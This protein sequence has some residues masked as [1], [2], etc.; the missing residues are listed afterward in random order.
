MRRLYGLL[1][2]A[3]W[4][5]RAGV[6]FCLGV[7]AVGAM[8]PFYMVFLLIPAF[9]GLN[10]LIVSAPGGRAAAAVGWWFGLG[11]F[12]SGL[13][14]ISN[15]LVISLE[16]FGPPVSLAPYPAVLALAAG[17]ALYPALV[18][19]LVWRLGRGLPGV[20]RV[21]VLAAV[22]AAVEW[23]RGWLLTGFPWNPV[24]AA[25][26]FSDEMI[27]SVALIGTYG[28]GLL[29]VGAAAMPGV[30]GTGG[31][32]R[33]VVVA[34]A[35]VAAVWAGGAARLAGAPTDMV[36]GVRLR[37]VQPNIA[38]RDKWRPNLRR[39][40]LFEQIRMSKL[41][42]DGAPPTLVIW[43][44]TASTYVLSQDK[45][46]R[47]VV[48]GAVPRGG[49]LITGAPRSTPLGAPERQ[50]WNSLHALDGG[51]DIVATYDKQHLVPFG[52]YMPLKD[53]FGI[54]KLTE[55]A[56]DFTP[57]P[58]PRTINLDGLPPVSPLIC[59]EVIFP[60]R[61]VDRL[62]RPDW[63]LNITND[64]WYGASSGPYQHFDQAR[65]RAVE[66]GLPLVRVANTGISA[67]V[68]GYGRIL[69]K[70]DLGEKGVLDGGLPRPAQ[71]RTLYGRLADWIVWMLILMVL[72]GGFLMR[73]TD[74]GTGAEEDF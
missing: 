60:G 12:V 48:A 67:I 42:A 66:E 50:V 22:W 5:R 64:G 11:Y 21:L 49:L 65:L 28:L 24:G 59:Y 47:N 15:A 2:E 74:G 36:E 44:E 9:T 26:T 23:L 61:V 13:Y 41:P 46:A 45:V 3:S 14:W 70:L 7:L 30:L 51:G 71:G 1:D 27:Q 4:W 10:W 8:A 43:S 35:L 19:V 33:P 69:G 53:W 52:E 32:K 55:G 25:W 57:G 39:D 29:T 40:N 20:G 6:A 18:S 54:G 34:L 62:N 31:G 16:K 38:Q 17:F 72:G 68:D 73:E 63:L 56:T 58:G 37:L